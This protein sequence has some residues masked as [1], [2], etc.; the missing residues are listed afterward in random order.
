MPS[1]FKK[2]VQMSDQIHGTFCGE[3][4]H[5]MIPITLKLIAVSFLVLFSNTDEL[6][7]IWCLF[8]LFV[9]G[10]IYVVILREAHQIFDFVLNDTNVV[11]GDGI[12][13]ISTI[14]KKPIL[15]GLDDLCEQFI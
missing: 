10:S 4:A 2:F 6:L 11:V 15:T 9:A 12:N 5:G 1:N 3:V 7:E 14:L 13:L 8:V